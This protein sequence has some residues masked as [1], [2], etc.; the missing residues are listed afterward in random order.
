MSRG[1][2]V[3][4]DGIEFVIRF[5]GS[6]SRDRNG[7]SRGE[8]ELIGGFNVDDQGQA[9]PVKRIVPNRHADWANDA[10]KA[11]GYVAKTAPRNPHDY[12]RDRIVPAHRGPA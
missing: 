5:D 4:V 6:W 1:D 7:V 3:I 9:L 11:G 10:A 2:T 8:D 12:Q